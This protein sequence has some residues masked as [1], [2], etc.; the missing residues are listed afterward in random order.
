MKKLGILK[1]N[2]LSYAELQNRE[3][4]ALR[5]GVGCSCSCY[6]TYPD[7]GVADQN[8]IPDGSGPC[9]CACRCNVNLPE[10]Y[11]QNNLD[12]GTYEY[13]TTN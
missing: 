5:G 8:H 2:G 6:G 7:S 1:L 11:A 9:S 3:M 13:G 12:Q 10:E 4:N